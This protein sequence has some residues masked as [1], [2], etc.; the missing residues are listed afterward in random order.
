MTI[1]ELLKSTKIKFKENDISSY[2]I[3]ALLLIAHHFNLTREE[4]IFSGNSPLDKT[5]ITEFETLINRRINK[6]PVSKIIGKKGFYED[7]FFVN[8]NVLDPRPDSE[9]LIEEVL[10]T[11]TDKNVKLKI[12]ELGVGSGCLILTILKKL[13][14]S[15]GIAVDINE[16]SLEV[17]RINSQNL[18]VNQRI[19]FQNSNWFS[20]ISDKNFDLIIS[21]P[22]YIKSEDINFLEADVKNFDP[23]I[24]LDGGEDGLD[25]YRIIAQNVKNFLN[26]NGY[27]FLEIGQNQEHEITEIFCQNGL[28]FI[29]SQ[30]DLG[31]IIRC[32]IFQN[33]HIS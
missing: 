32:L 20:N 3:D 18:G 26:E 25:C 33:A 22:P 15:H 23:L 30:K 9:T 8:Q 12:L 11:F 1:A 2:E 4:I 6:E 28:K 13:P 17:A 16:K 19:K 21:N 24:A 7:D 14:N 10:K 5:K 31:Q 29:K 27:L